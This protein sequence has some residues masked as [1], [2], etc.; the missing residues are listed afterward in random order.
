MTT[1]LGQL[2]QAVDV[3]DEQAR[4]ARGPNWNEQVLAR[5]AAALLKENLPALWQAATKKPEPPTPP[6]AAG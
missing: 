1:N 6:P 2:L 4:L 5:Q 3:L